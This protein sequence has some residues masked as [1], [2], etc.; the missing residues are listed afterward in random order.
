MTLGDLSY[1]MKYAFVSSVQG[2]LVRPRDAFL[3]KLV[4]STIELQKLGYL[5]ILLT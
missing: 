4:L 1:M 3:P 5:S 2:N